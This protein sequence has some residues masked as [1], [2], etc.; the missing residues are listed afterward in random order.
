[1][2][3]VLFYLLSILPLLGQFEKITFT[4]ADDLVITADLYR[5]HESKETPMIVL[6]HQAGSSRGE[7]RD[8]APRLVEMGFNCL[9]VDQRSGGS[10]NGVSNETAA[11][12]EGNVTFLDAVPDLQAA[13][14][15]AKADYS[16]GPLVIWGSSYSSTLVLKLIG[17]DLELADG[18]L[19]FSPGEYLGGGSPVRAAA[20]KVKA[21]TFITSASNEESAARPIFEAI[22]ASEKTYFLP[23]SGG[24]HGSS[25]LNEGVLNQAAYWEATTAFLSQFLP[26]ETA[27]IKVM[28]TPM[29]SGQLSLSFNGSAGK[30]YRLSVTSDLKRWLSLA[31][32]TA[33]DDTVTMVDA[34]GASGEKLFYR[35]QPIVALV[36]PEITA[37]SASG[38]PGS[39]NF[40]VAI[41]S[42]ETGWERYADWWEVL[43][44]EGK[45]IYRRVLGH[46][47]V[48]EQPFTRGGGPVRIQADDIVWIRAHMNEGGYGKAAFKGSVSGG[49]EAT[50]LSSVFASEVAVEGD[51]PRER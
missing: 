26:G 32:I 34:A 24:Q 22:P 17:E 19:S 16:S 3:T 21:P 51:L 27:A 43:D 25:T 12:V 14:A 1:M 48:N 15:K 10:R 33:A 37:V 8:I 5:A 36:E 41:R 9:A 2:K 13:I 50:E 18:V 20:A 31:S 42:D 4:A 47:H 30:N 49:F 11:R 46:P 45:L 39:D 7:Y 35:A 40:S 23:T 6:F 44:E 38:S 28:A 29:A